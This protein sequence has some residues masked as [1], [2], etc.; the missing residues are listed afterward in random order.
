LSLEE[1]GAGT[2]GDPTAAKPGQ[3]PPEPR[4]GWRELVDGVDAIVWEAD[5]ETFQFGFVSQG[6]QRMLGFPRG[7]WLASEE[8]WPGIIH[9]EDRDA[10]VRYCAEMTRAGKDHR[11][12]YR[13]L[14]REGEVVWV[15]DLVSVVTDPVGAPVLLRGTMIDV[16]ETR[17]AVE[18]LEE[19]ESRHRLLA[20][21][22]QDL[23][24][25][26]SRDGRFLYL[27][28]SCRDILG[29]EPWEL[30]GAPLE[31]VIHPEDL[32]ELYSAIETI[33]QGGEL[34][35][36]VFR[37]IRKDGT[38]RWCET[39]GVPERTS[40][41]NHPPRLVGVTRDISERRLLQSELE[42]A[43]RLEALGRLAGG[44]AHDFSNL[45]TVIRGH[46]E[47][48]REVMPLREELNAEL[49]SM[50][51]AVERAGTLTRQLLTFGRRDFA[52][53]ERLDLGEGLRKVEELLGRV[54][55]ENISLRFESPAEPLMARLDRVHFEQVLVNLALNAR[56][57]MPHG[58][59]LEVDLTRRSL[60]GREVE[61]LPG[62]RPGAHALIRVL[63]TGVGMDPDTLPQIFDPFFT[64][65][66]SDQGTGLGLAIVYGVV[67]Q[68]G[69]VIQ[70]ESR[71]NAGTSFRIW[72][73][74]VDAADGDGPSPLEG[75]LPNLP[76]PP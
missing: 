15:R 55:P 56:D 52:R 3:L 57:A 32:P 13:V 8:F 7:E 31:R 14:D 58:G 76:S 40:S 41:S 72:L 30:I 49:E 53:P 37:A 43:Q 38:L 33:L 29:Y 46:L 59:R 65:K 51:Q 44:V 67:R 4:G 39:K 61:R 36:A 28:P 18:A 34:P 45:L 68:S 27:S 64:T 25:L 22:I 20:D 47:F 60:E 5:P 10:A 69:G 26:H 42:R 11:L 63:D 73:P 74:L 12:E 50:E 6:A 62:L 24:S 35:A 17:R 54:L 48:F 75:A 2:G 16:T 9:P 19:E 66:R 1:N 70:V 21:H 23:V 71:K